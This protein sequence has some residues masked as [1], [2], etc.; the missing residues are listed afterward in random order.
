MNGRKKEWEV[1]FEIVQN[2]IF[3][4]HAMFERV[5]FFLAFLS[6]AVHKYSKINITGNCLS[7]AMLVGCR[8]EWSTGELFSIT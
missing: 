5:L 4:D 6:P 2:P 1:K 8:V 7:Q 3:S